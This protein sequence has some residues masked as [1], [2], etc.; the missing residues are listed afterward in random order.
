MDLREH[1]GTTI[2]IVTHNMG[3]VS[4]MADKVAVMYAGSI[5]EYGSKTDV[6]NHPKHPYT[7]ALID[8]IP[9]IGG[10]IPK[11]FRDSR[12]LLERY[13]Q[14]VVFLQMQFIR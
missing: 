4:H 9:Q 6:L 2:I 5:V 10:T 8:S 11:G 1:L 12:L 13:L 7:K 14:A 3:V